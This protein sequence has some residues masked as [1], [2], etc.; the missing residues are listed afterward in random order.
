LFLGEL[1]EIY[2]DPKVGYEKLSQ[3]TP[4]VAVLEGRVEL[5]VYFEPALLSGPIGHWYESHLRRAGAELAPNPK[6]TRP[7]AVYSVRPCGGMRN[8]DLLGAISVEQFEQAR[9]ASKVAGLPSSVAPNPI[10]QYKSAR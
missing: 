10:P 7:L 9:R 5:A 1:A 8:S 6:F 2:A 3:S 4:I